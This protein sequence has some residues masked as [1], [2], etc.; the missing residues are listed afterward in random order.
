MRTNSQDHLPRG[1]GSDRERIRQYKN[2][3]VVTHMA[4]QEQMT[5]HVDELTLF[6]GTREQAAMAALLDNGEGNGCLVEAPPK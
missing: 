3:A 1:K 4:S 2:D 5:Y 6:V